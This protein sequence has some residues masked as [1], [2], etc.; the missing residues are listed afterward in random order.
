MATLAA[1]RGV[2]EAGVELPVASA[3]PSIESQGNLAF[4]PLAQCAFPDDRNSPAS[5]EQVA[6]VASVPFGVRNELRSPELLA[7]GRH[8]GV[9][10][11]SVSV[12]EAA[13]DETDGVEPA[14]HEVWSA[15][16]SSVVQT[17]SE[18]AGVDGSTKSEFRTRVSA[19]DPRHYARPGRAVHCVC[20]G[21]PAGSAG[22]HAAHDRLHER[23]ST[24]ADPTGSCDAALNWLEP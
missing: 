21:R 14:K 8:G 2:E 11:A 3:Q 19:S 20:H 23:L 7:R 6:S 13:V 17:V 18:P 22:R 10:T 24:R 9:P 4:N 1:D 5:L 12:P 15:R 16:E